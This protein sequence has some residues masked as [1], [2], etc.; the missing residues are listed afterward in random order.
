MKTG[1]MVKSAVLENPYGLE[2]G[3]WQDLRADGHMEGQ[4][5]VAAKSTECMSLNAKSTTFRSAT[6]GK[7]HNLSASVSSSVKLQ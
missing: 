7:L 6:L 5:D 1:R 4:Q 3:M 2:E